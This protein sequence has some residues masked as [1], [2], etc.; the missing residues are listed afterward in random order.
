M[1]EK[2]PHGS[3]RVD[4]W[5]M[6]VVGRDHRIQALKPVKR[7]QGAPGVDGMTVE[8]LPDSLKQPLARHQGTTDRWALPSTARATG[9]EAQARR[10]HAQTGYSDG[11]RPPD[12]ASDSPSPA[13]ALGGAM[14][15]Q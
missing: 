8:A 11:H 15:P 1:G 14:P 9:R 7:N 4:A 13:L 12:P 6:Q 2:R 3:T 5:M 10:A